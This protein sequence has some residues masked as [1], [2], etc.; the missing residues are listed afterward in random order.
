M[1]SALLGYL[2]RG[3]ARGAKPLGVTATVAYVA[4]GLLVLWSAY[5]H[6]HLWAE[7]QGYRQLSV[8]G[9]LF[10]V[11]SIGG[12]VL[13]ILVIAIRRVWVAIGGIGFAA[14]T[15]AG[16]LLTV[17]LP[18]GLFNF[19]E[20]WSAPFAH[21]AFAIDQAFAIE[22]AIIVVL[23][24]A[25]ALSFAGPSSSLSGVRAGRQKDRLRA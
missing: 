1:Q 24:L 15:I 11:Q 10:L 17:A 13:G 22:V 23:L 7:P 6:F 12:L 9:P 14:S 8:I 2:G 21:Q 25:G 4:G 3:P 20:T 18:H 19:Q 16:F 5:I